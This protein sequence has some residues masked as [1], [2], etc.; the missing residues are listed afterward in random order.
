M[1]YHQNA[2]LT[3]HSREQLAKMVVEQGRH[4]EGRRGGLQREREDGRQVGAPLSEQGGPDCR[5]A[6]RGRIARRGELHLLYWKRFWLFAGCARTAGAS[7]S[8]ST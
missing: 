2:R 3:I 6:V 1:D 5:T 4:V 7:L 8:H